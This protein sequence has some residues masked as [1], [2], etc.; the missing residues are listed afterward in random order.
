VN[1]IFRGFETRQTKTEV[2]EAVNVTATE[3]PIDNEV[4][5]DGWQW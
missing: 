2:E 4:N 3:D 1:T 5:K